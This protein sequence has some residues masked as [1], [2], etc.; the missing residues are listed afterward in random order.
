ML[1]NHKRL[2]SSEIQKFG[3]TFGDMLNSYV[4]HL[5]SLKMRP[6]YRVELDLDTKILANVRFGSSGVRYTV[7]FLVV[8]QCLQIPFEQQSADSKGDK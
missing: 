7:F 3:T 5:R 4:Q 6:C 2:I 1:F 8:L